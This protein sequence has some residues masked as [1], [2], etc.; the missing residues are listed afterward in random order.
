MYD[1]NLFKNKSLKKKDRMPKKKNKADPK[2][3]KKK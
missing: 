2:R 3:K 1:T